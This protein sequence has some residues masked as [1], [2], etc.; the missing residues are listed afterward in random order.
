MDSIL[1]RFFICKQ[2]LP[3]LCA[4]TVDPDKQVRDNA[5][6]TIKV[7]IEKLEKASNNPE[8]AAKMSEYLIQYRGVRK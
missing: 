1:S 7:F 8:E 4:T 2:A 3:A 5:F 6:K